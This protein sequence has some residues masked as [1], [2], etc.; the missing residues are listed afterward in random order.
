MDRAATRVRGGYSIALKVEIGTGAEAKLFVCIELRVGA[1]KD[2]LGE[3]VFGMPSVGKMVVIGAVLE[4]CV[5]GRDVGRGGAERR[6]EKATCAIME[7]WQ[8]EC[9]RIRVISVVR[10][11][12]CWGVSWQTDRS[13]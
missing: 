5:D 6:S 4:R 9:E 8:R 7:R 2:R 13:S 3:D 10:G 11:G 12:C 1:A